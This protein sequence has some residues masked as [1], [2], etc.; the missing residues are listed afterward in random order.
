[1]ELSPAS[2]RLRVDELVLHGFAPADRHRIADAMRDELARL[3]AERGVPERLARGEAPAELDAGA[4]EVPGGARPAE[5]GRR[6]AGAL[7][8]GFADAGA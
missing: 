4:F 3:F 1:M 7:Y 6:L 2:V 8:R 5:V